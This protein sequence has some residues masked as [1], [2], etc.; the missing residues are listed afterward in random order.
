MIDI[1]QSYYASERRDA[2]STPAPVNTALRFSRP[3]ARAPH[4][5]GARCDT[6][7]GRV[8]VL[9]QAEVAFVAIAGAAIDEP[10]VQMGPFVMNSR[11]EAEQAM[12]DYQNGRFGT[13]APFV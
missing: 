12:R 10:V 2:M 1:I 6:P 4:P 9:A 8:Q 11:E 3:V 5:V 7:S 13:V